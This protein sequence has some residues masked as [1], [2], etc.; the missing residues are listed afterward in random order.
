MLPLLVSAL[1]FPPISALSLPLLRPPPSTQHAGLI[2]L[3]NVCLAS[4]LPSPLPS[5]PS[6]PQAPGPHR[7]SSGPRQ[8]GEIEMLRA[9]TTAPLI[10]FPRL[11]PA[12]PL[13]ALSN[14]GPARREGGRN[15]GGRTNKHS[16]LTMATK[17][18]QTKTVNAKMKRLK[19]WKERGENA[20]DHPHSAS[21][22]KCKIR[23]LRS[24]VKSVDCYHANA[25]SHYRDCAAR[26]RSPTPASDP[27]SSQRVQ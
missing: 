7:S 4:A 11:I 12:D 2:C 13:V 1:L 22:Y 15:R 5:S 17:K 25:P 10:K 14:R 8:P 20:H 6:S 16:T 27:S 18:N 3:S 21:A 9:R 24:F 23:A 19:L 26:L